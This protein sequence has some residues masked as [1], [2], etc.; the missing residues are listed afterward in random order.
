MAKIT[1][2]KKRNGQIAEFDQ[3]KITDA[4]WHAAKSVGGTNKDLATQISNQVTA[5]LEIFYKGDGTVPN[6]E[7]IQDLVEK[8][9]IEG[10]HAQTAK[11]YILYRSQHDAIRENQ[12]KLLGG[13]T[14]QLPFSPNALK[15]IAGKYLQRDENGNVYE[16]PE[17]M[18]ERIAKSI[19]N[20]EKDYGKSKEEIKDINEKFLKMLTD[21]EF[22]PAGRTIANAG[23]KNRLVSNCIVIHFE[24]SMEGIFQTLKDAALLQ[25]A[26]SGL[27]FAWHLLRPAGTRAKST[28]GMASGPV[29]FLRAFNESFGVIKQQG[30]H[31]ANM[32]VM[33]VDHPDILE[34]IESKYKEGA[35]VNFNISVSLTDEFM[36]QV[37]NKSTEPWLCTWKGKKMKPRRIIRNSRG[38]FIEAQEETLTAMELMDKIIELAWRNGEPGVLFPDAANRANPVPELGELH[39]TN[40][41]GEQWLHDGD[42]CNLGSINLA[43]FVKNNDIDEKRLEEVTRLGVRLL[44]NV[45]DMTDFP[46]E[47][48]NST[49]RNNRRIGLGI[50]GF[51]DMLYQMRLSYASKEGQDLARRV[52]GLINRTAEDESHKLALEKGS[53]PNWHLSIFNEKGQNIPRRNSALTTVAPT[54]SISML[55]DCSSG[56]EPFF[57]LAY[58]KE[59]MNGQ[60]MI[61]M[62]KFLKKELKDLGLYTE[63]IIEKIKVDGSV[64]NIE[65]IPAEIKKIYVTAMDISAEAHIK[66]QAAFQEHV[67]NSISKTI[68]FPN[69]ATR[70][71]VKQGYIMAWEAGLK[72]C[73]VYRDGSR[74]EQVLSVESTKTKTAED[75][76]TDNT[77]TTIDEA[78]VAKEISL[79]PIAETN[80]RNPEVSLN[81]KDV[82]KSGKCPECNAKI[83]IAEGCMHCVSCGYSACSV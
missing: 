47:K 82:I 50:M 36:N 42:V 49:F 81:K 28:S 57:A 54:G 65:E 66:M 24:D 64:Q 40:P 6:V 35:L 17:E 78:P 80:R 43:K 18:Y 76:K 29:S 60:K 67:D 61:Y 23:T 20:V 74:S 70:Q 22:I 30:R 37:K 7:Q 45:I 69:S 73:T 58:Q 11:A 41:C 1:K 68:N 51:A 13:K 27:G 55:L 83:H 79:P 26:G 34:F 63:E 72:G 10:G 16:T 75:A 77:Q 12:E 59:V 31:G 3:A 21:F 33:R 52:M 32:G 44:D 53:F 25:Q 46:V 14:T 39:A 15:I 38:A 48:V 71:D 9:L 62:N 19:A 8:I 5:V 4:I 56:V 2:I